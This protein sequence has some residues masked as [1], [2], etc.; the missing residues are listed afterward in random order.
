M[1]IEGLRVA[2]RIRSDKYRIFN[3]ELAH[4]YG[5]KESTYIAYLRKE[6]MY[7]GKIYC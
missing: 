5:L 4:Y 2:D 7:N 1:N 6:K 3:K